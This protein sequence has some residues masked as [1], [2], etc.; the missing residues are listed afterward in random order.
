MDIQRENP[1]DWARI[2]FKSSKTSFGSLVT[3][4]MHYLVQS[5]F[6]VKGKKEA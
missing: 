6:S 5:Q 1:G 4:R 2:Q 3:R